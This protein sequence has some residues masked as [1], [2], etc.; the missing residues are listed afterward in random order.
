MFSR[1]E[2]Q[3]GAE[4]ED[5]E[6]AMLEELKRAYFVCCCSAGPQD[7]SEAE[8]TLAQQIQG[9]N[10][11][12]W[13]K[14]CPMKV[15]AVFCFFLSCHKRSLVI[16]T[17]SS[18]GCRM[19]GCECK[20]VCACTAC[21]EFAYLCVCERSW[22]NEMTRNCNN[23]KSEGDGSSLFIHMHQTNSPCFSTPHQMHFIFLEHI[24]R[25]QFWEMENPDLFV[26][27]KMW[28]C[29]HSRHFYFFIYIF[30][31]QSV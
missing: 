20:W 4:L 22:A 12:I 25:N 8:E 30:W 28:L 2:M 14:C 17:C 7:P 23:K 15:H 1:W 18:Q 21:S 10:T 6:K 24:S 27:D 11:T 26:W 13:W 9:G 31:S 19:C 3:E 5:G 29:D 16:Y